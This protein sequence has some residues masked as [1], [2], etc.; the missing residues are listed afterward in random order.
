MENMLAMS[1]LSE[2]FKL[3]SWVEDRRNIAES[4]QEGL[5]FR[6][7]VKNDERVIITLD[8][9]QIFFLLCES[10]TIFEIIERDHDMI[11]RSGFEQIWIP[12]R[13]NITGIQLTTFLDHF[14]NGSAK[15]SIDTSTESIVRISSFLRT[16][17]PIF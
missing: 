7:F 14:R 1:E 3:V 10:D 13:V 11:R 8:H 12:R 4:F 5:K 15:Y 9:I 2:T 16:N 6:F 17:Y